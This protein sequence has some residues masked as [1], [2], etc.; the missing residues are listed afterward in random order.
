MHRLSTIFAAILLAA[1]PV[2]AAEISEAQKG[3]VETIIRDYLMK[4]PEVLRDALIELQ[5]REE[6]KSAVSLKEALRQNADA[7]YR[8]SGDFAIGKADA[9]VT[10]VEF[11]DYNCG[12]CKKSLPDIV[13]LM[14]ADEDVKVIFKEFPILSPGSV[15][16]ARAAIASRQ[17]GKYWELHQALM[18][19]AGQKDE[20]TVLAIAE[21]AGLDMAKLKADMQAPEVN[22]ILTANMELAKALGIQGTPAFI[23][24]EKLI[25]GA[26]GADGLKSLVAEIRSQGGCTIC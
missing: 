16:A 17:Q 6:A 26:V 20:A 24:S 7:L 1:A 11:L 2:A 3:E 21:K 10:I 15:V 22:E 9:S 23:A 4:N 18:E 25:P 5:R 14:E 19:F 8:S 12:Y 13:K